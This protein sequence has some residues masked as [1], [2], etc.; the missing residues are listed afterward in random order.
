MITTHNS[1]GV[2]AIELPGRSPVDLGDDTILSATLSGDGRATL[3]LRRW[4]PDQHVYAG[5]V[6]DA[7][8]SVGTPTRRRGVNH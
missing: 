5:F 1:L 6:R 7:F 8:D 2:A 3:L 4:L